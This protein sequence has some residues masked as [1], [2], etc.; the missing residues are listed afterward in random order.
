MAKPATEFV[1]V[2]VLPGPAVIEAR[3]TNYLDP[4]P[5]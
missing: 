3:K 5:P 2:Q 1:G 4:L